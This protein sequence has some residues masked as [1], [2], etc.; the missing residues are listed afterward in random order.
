MVL[1]HLLS[2]SSRTSG[3]NR[4]WT[5]AAFTGV[6]PF[7]AGTPDPQS[8]VALANARQQISSVSWFASKMRKL[9]IRRRRGLTISTIDRLQELYP[10]GRFETRR[11]RP[12]IVV[13]TASEDGSF[14]ESD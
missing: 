4:S 14:V 5:G 1:I 13:S 6:G 12:N 11:F 9:A 8:R 3:P 2:P 7:G 10:Q